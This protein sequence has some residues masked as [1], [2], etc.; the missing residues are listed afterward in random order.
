[1]STIL[2]FH[3]RIDANLRAILTSMPTIPPEEI[4]AD[5][6]LCSLG[7]DEGDSPGFLYVAHDEAGEFVSFIIG[8]A[9]STEAESVCMTLTSRQATEL[10]M[11]LL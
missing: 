3:R 6:V 7:D 10:G 5:D 4:F 1:M 9:G 2:K 8:A 11:A